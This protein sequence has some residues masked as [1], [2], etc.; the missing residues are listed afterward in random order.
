MKAARVLIVEDEEVV[1]RYLRRDGYSVCRVADGASASSAF[2]AFA[3]DL[4]VL[5]L[6]LPGMDG[7]DVCGEIRKTSD[8]PIVML[9][10]RKS[11]E[12]KLTGLKLGAD[13]YVTKPFSPREVAARVQ[14][15][16]RRAA[17]RESAEQPTGP[18]R[19]GQLSIDESARTV[20]VGDDLVD[21]TL[22]EFDLLVCMARHPRQ[23][24]TREALLSAVWGVGY[25]FE[26]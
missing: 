7:L 2:A 13:D 19:F 24:F 17:P 16:L 25:R 9:T 4:I 5:D 20:E 10:S 26:P 18:T 3:P 6:M 22:R 12:D 8:V 23:A 15:I 21:L 11:E 1:Q 14:A